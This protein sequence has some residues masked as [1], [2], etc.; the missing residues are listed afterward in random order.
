MI[1]SL[2]NAYGSL[3]KI[4]NLLIF[5]AKQDALQAELLETR[6]VVMDVQ[7]DAARII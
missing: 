3:A 1:D 2:L 4:G 6:N 7:K 5:K